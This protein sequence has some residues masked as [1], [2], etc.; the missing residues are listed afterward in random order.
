MFVLK[1]KQIEAFKEIEREKFVYKSNIFLEHNFPDFT[2]Q[3]GPIKC[4]KFINDMIDFGE[5][6][7]IFKEINVQKLM[8]LK[9]E[10]KF[11]TP[12]NK[13]LEAI[14]KPQQKS[15]DIRVKEFFKTLFDETQQVIKIKPK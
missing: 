10:Y 6:Y 9:I 7:H 3:Q 11:E 1:E 12:L 2:A 13:E 5:K 8:F 14:L 15:E 4:T